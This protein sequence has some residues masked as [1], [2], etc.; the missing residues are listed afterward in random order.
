MSFD[1]KAKSVGENKKQEDNR[2]V[3]RSGAALTFV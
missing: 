1:E 2:L 3:G